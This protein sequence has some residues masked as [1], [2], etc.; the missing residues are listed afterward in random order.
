M[1]T[2][3]PGQSTPN[4]DRRQTRKTRHK[5]G[6]SILWQPLYAARRL[7]QPKSPN[8]DPNNQTAGGTG[9]TA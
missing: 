7:I 6:S 1:K 2:R 4:P 3:A 5:A 9:T 8:A